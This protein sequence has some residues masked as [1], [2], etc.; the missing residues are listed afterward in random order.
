LVTVGPPGVTVSVGVVGT[1]LVGA[2]AVV[3]K[4][5]WVG[6][7]GRAV[8]APGVGV[9]GANIRAKKPAQ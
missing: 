8:A 5:N 1:S 9:F 3:G 7:D 4:M 2:A 6:V